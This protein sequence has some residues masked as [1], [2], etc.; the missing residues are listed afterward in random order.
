MSDLEAD[1]RSSRATRFKSNESHA[2]TESPPDIS[3]RSET[4]RIDKKRETNGRI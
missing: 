2:I 3:A 4:A 1:A